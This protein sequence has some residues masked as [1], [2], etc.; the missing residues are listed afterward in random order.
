[1]DDVTR[2]DLE[3]IEDMHRQDIAATRVGDFEVLKSLM[4]AE[5]MLFPPD[6]EPS[7][8]QAYLDHALE[9]SNGTESQ[10]EILELVQ[11]WEEVRL[12]GDFAY[13]QGVVRYAVRD[14]TGSITRETQRLMRILR[15]QKD[16]TW[17]VYRA[18]WHAPRRA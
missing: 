3:A 15:C 12:L 2:K 18:M 9:S 11:E 8:G 4:D 7:V 6:S 14:A 1:M 17:R 5:C 10:S 16:G 13:E